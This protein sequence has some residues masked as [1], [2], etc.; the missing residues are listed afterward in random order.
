MLFSSKSTP[1]KHITNTSHN[2]VMEELSELHSVDPASVD[3]PT[4]ESKQELDADSAVLDGKVC[5]WGGEV[6]ERGAIPMYVLK[7]DLGV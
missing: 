1:K 2:V 6:D 4:D 3:E 5:V 7:K